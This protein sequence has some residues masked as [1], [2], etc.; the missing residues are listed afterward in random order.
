MSMGQ[1]S[2]QDLTVAFTVAN[3]P[4]SVREARRRIAPLRGELGER[5]HQDLALL[6]SELIGNAVRHAH[7]AKDDRVHVRV[8]CR[9]GWVRGEVADPGPGFSVRM[10]PSPNA[11]GVGGYGL[12][13]VSRLASRWGA[14]RVDGSTRVWF[15]LDGNA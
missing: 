6:L 9:P 3:A 10:T 13:L 2:P 15:E 5:L 4:K 8:E 12:T 14:E 1:R 7:L 11:S